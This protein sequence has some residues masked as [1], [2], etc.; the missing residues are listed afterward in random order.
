VEIG[1]ADGFAARFEDGATRRCRT[2]GTRVY[3][4]SGRA[5]SASR[6]S[7]EGVSTTGIPSAPG[8]RGRD[9]PISALPQGGDQLVLA[10]L[11]ASFDAHFLRLLVCEVPDA[12]PAVMVDPERIEQVLW[13]QGFQGAEEGCYTPT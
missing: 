7:V 11:G 1:S 13:N 5:L 3:T 12:C 4:G 9:A 10:D 8:E 6:T 2:V